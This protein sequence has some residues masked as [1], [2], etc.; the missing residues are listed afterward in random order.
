MRWVGFSDCNYM[1][2]R[3]WNLN[4]HK[5]RLY[6]RQMIPSAS[7]PILYSSTFRNHDYNFGPTSAA[8]SMPAPAFTP[9]F[10]S[11][12][13]HSGRRASTEETILFLMNTF[14]L[15]SRCAFWLFLHDFH[16]SLKY[17]MPL[18]RALA[19]FFAYCTVRAA[20]TSALD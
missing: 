14:Q 4:R 15:L 10:D 6:L 2:R 11:H 20:G 18:C 12:G 8:T 3:A 13:L 16:I 19:V 1:F 5:H 7:V 17:G 9:V